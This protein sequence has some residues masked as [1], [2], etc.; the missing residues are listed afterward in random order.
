MV[1]AARHPPSA[2]PRSDGDA[3]GVLWEVGL[4]RDFDYVIVGAGSAG[5]V[6]AHRLAVDPDVRVLLLEAGPRDWSPF[7]RMPAAFAYAIAGRRFNW[8]YTTEPEPYLGGRE[9]PC[10]RGR[11]LGGSSSINAMAYVRGQGADFDG[12]ADAG[13]PDWDYAHCLPYFKKLETFHGPASDFR[14]TGGPLDVTAPRYTSPLCEVFL[15]ACEQAGFARNADTN[16]REQEGVGPMDQTIHAARRVSTAAAYLRPARGRPN[17]EVRTKCL[18]TRVL[19]EG[20]RAVGVEAAAGGRVAAIRA[21]REVILCGGAINSPQLL[22]LS[23]IGAADGLRALAIPVV[24]DLPG[25]GQGMQDHVDVSVKQAATRPVTATPA[26]RFPHNAML[27]LEWYLFGTGLGATSHFEVAGYIRTSPEQERPTIQVSFI[28]LLVNYDGSALAEAHGYQATVMLLRPESRGSISL[29]SA[30]PRAG[31]A[32]LFNYFESEADLRGLR[33]GLRSTRHIFGQRAFSPYRGREVDPGADAESDAALDAF[34]RRTVKT[35]NHPSCTCRMGVDAR[36]VVDAQ[37]R[38]RGV[39]GLRVIDAS[40][41][42]AVTSGNIN[43][44]TIMLAEKLADRVLGKPPL[45][46]ITFAG[47]G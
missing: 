40:I 39:E 4:A 14:G 38:V 22:M 18:V 36:A 20:A 25:V 42:P 33:S 41:L 3:E 45:E 23:G 1:L 43:A 31:P 17:L 34:M 11:V 13:L 24:A 2:S 27:F 29:R 9:A 37:G 35:T 8:K 16:A 21:G 5:C 30:D 32:I 46:P 6:L 19:F 7:L 28:P 15:D 47:G 26:L 44:P 12:W 10:D